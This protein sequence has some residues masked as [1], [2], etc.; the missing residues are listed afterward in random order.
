MD[1]GR[2]ESSR[3]HIGLCADCRHSRYIENKKGHRF[4]RCEKSKSDPR[5]APYP[6]LPVRVCSG[7][8]S[9]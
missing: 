6:R 7:Y 8:Q 1:D 9:A 4:Y 2:P 3:P 5:F